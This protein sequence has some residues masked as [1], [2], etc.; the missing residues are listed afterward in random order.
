M[1][2]SI[3]DIKEMKQKREKIPMLTAYDY[4]TAKNSRRG[5]CALDI[6]RG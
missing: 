6:G 2:V 3:T 4:V 1:R 5:W